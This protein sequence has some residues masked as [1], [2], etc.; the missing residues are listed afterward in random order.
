MPYSIYKSIKSSNILKK[1][2]KGKNS[3]NT[4]VLISVLSFYK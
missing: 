4:I 3:I 2:G 1:N